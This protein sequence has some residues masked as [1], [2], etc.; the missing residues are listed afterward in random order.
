MNAGGRGPFVIIFTQ[1]KHNFTRGVV[2]AQIMVKRDVFEDIIRREHINCLCGGF[3]PEVAFRGKADVINPK[4]R[5]IHDYIIH[6]R[7]VVR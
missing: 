4:V 3:R 6:Q 7:E 2:T 5:G 1:P